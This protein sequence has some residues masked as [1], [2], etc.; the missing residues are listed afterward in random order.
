MQDLN[1]ADSFSKSFIWCICDFV[2]VAVM[3]ASFGM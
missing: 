3:A 1:I 2:L